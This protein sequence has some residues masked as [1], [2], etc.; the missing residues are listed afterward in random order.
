M[1]NDEL[2]EALLNERPVMADIMLLGEIEFACV[3][4]IEYSND[5]GKIKVSVKLKDKCNENSFTHVMPR[6]VR[7]K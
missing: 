7:Y 6:K 1:T 3:A 5:N 2:K 4:G